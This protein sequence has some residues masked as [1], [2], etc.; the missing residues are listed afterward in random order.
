[1]FEF[2]VANRI[3]G[4]ELHRLCGGSRMPLTGRFDGTW[5]AARTPW[6]AGIGG[7]SNLKISVIGGNENITGIG[8]G[9]R[10]GKRN[11]GKTFRA[12]QPELNNGIAGSLVLA[13]TVVDTAADAAVEQYEDQ[14]EEAA[15]P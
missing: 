5:E 9:N 12:Q 4:T 10:N 1:M 8:I 14:G 2:A 11:S 13:E 15:G 7:D 6:N 3:E